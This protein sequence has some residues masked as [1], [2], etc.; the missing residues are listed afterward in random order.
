MQASSATA[1]RSGTRPLCA[2]RDMTT[3]RA[4]GHD[5]C[6][7]SY[8]MVLVWR[9]HGRFEEND[10]KFRAGYPKLKTTNRKCNEP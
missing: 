7:A 5:H 2:L 3:V 10:E 9:F 6:V 4:Q 8:L 1:A